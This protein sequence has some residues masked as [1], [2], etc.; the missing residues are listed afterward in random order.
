[1]PQHFDVIII[2]AGVSGLTIA[3][4]LLQH[5]KSVLILEANGHIGGRCW[6]KNDM[7]MGATWVH[8]CDTI[9]RFSN[10][11]DINMCKQTSC[12]SYIDPDVDVV[13]GVPT[14]T[15][16]EYAQ[17]YKTFVSKSKDATYDDLEKVLTH[18]ANSEPLKQVLAYHRAKMEFHE[19]QNQHIE[20]HAYTYDGMPKKTMY[21]TFVEPYIDKLKSHIRLRTPVKSIRR[22]GD[23]FVIDTSRGAYT[24]R[25]FVY[26]GTFPALSNIK[27]PS[28]ILPQTIRYFMDKVVYVQVLKVVWNV[29]ERSEQRLKQ[30]FHKRRQLHVPG[31]PW[32]VMLH[33]KKG[34]LY[35]YAV[36]PMYLQVKDMHLRK[37]KTDLER[38]LDINI[39]DSSYIDYNKNKYFQGSY[40]ARYPDSNLRMQDN[41]MNPSPGFYMSGDTI[42]LPKAFDTWEGCIGTVTGA[43]RT[44]EHV[45]K[46]ILEAMP[47]WSI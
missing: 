5:S 20:T 38:M 9:K 45:A 22:A 7:D 39:T 41:I 35:T 12:D 11:A 26:T 15:L 17:I 1:M 36:G 25:Q 19:P 29:H 47:A 14:S 46:L 33:E 16:R 8:R 42:V 40:A 34:Y 43:I 21:T 2:G 27:M 37:M 6:A 28:N 13:Y 10:I 4:K 18:N 44:A 31:L 24:A 32:T 30:L 23:M 3:S